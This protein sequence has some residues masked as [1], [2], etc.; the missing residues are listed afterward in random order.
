MPGVVPEIGSSALR[1]WV[2]AGSAALLVALCAMAYGWAQ[3]KNLARLGIVALGAVLG[4][5]M[6]WAFLNGA[7]TRDQDAERRALQTRAAELNMQALAPGSALAC[8]DGLAGENVEVACEKALF[9][10]PASVASATSYAAS[11]L[12]LLADMAAY[13]TQGGADIDSLMVSLRRALETDRYGFVA[14][15]LAARDGCTSQNCKAL[16]LLRDA[17]KVRANLSGGT[18]DRYLERYVTVWNQPPESPVADASKPGEG[19]NAPPHHMVNIDFPTAASIPPVS[20]M[21]PEPPRPAAAAAAATASEANTHSGPAAKPRKGKPAPQTAAA[22]PPE[23]P[24]AVDPVWIPTTASTA[25]QP[26]AA[27]PQP[28][29][30]AA[31]GPVVT[32]PVQLNPF[33]SPPT[34]APQTA[35]GG[36]PPTQ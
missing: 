18:L 15:A 30:A 33:P 14:H 3:T 36:T 11:R 5:T 26:P 22:P 17:S 20:I 35:A 8:L 2:A 34:S 25:P 10:S 7:T 27:V 21:N 1:L 29:A 31:P 23:T 12:A 24:P 6:A 28:P 32:A 16:A 13:T 19:A 4:G 9:A